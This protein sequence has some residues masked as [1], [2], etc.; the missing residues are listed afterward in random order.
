MPIPKNKDE[1][2][3][4]QGIEQGGSR[5]EMHKGPTAQGYSTDKW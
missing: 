5:S 2:T 1:I 3:E 4:V